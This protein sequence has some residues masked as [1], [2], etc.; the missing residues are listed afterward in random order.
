M[1]TGGTGSGGVPNVPP[2]Q[3][4]SQGSG[5]STISRFACRLLV[6]RR[7]P[8]CDENAEKQAVVRLFAAGFNSESNIFLG[9]KATKWQENGNMDGLTTNGVLLMHPEGEFVGG[10][11]KPGEWREVSV[12]GSVFSL[13]EARSSSKRGEE[14]KDETN[15][16]HDGSLI[17]L[18]GAT[19]LWRSADGL[20]NSPTKRHVDWMIERINAGKPQCPVGLNTLV[21]PRTNSNTPASQHQN[22]YVYLQCGHVQGQHDWGVVEGAGPNER[23]CPMCFDVGRVA[24]LEMGL[25]PAFYVDFE[26]PTYAFNPCGHMAS[27]K[28][29]KYWSFIPFPHGPSGYRSMCPFCATSLEGYPGFTKL[30]FQ[31]NID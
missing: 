3:S 17:D 21:L 29:V 10:G 12:D 1:D 11:G 7:D 28:T 13:R 14:Q 25:E 6:T 23:Q 15:V 20:R 19:L 2:S 16:L 5:Q 9:E 31:D 26:P 30:I 8:A 4:Q 22:M 27:E 18:C 24:R